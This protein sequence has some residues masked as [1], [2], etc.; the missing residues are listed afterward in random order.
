MRNAEGLDFDVDL[1]D[2]GMLTI[3]PY[4]MKLPEDREWLEAL[5]EALFWKDMDLI[6]SSQ[7][8]WMYIYHRNTD[9]VFPMDDYGYN[10]ITNLERSEQAK[11]MGRD[12]HPD[13]DEYEWNQ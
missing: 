2:D 11:V 9:K 7:D 6:H 4:R 12:N 13:Y 1:A 5:N 10:L 3:T 8:G